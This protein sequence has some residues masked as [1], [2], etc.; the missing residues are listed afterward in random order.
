MLKV[1]K[2]RLLEFEDQL[3][4][5]DPESGRIPV[6]ILGYGEV[7]ATFQIGD[8][9][10]IAFKRMPPFPNERASV[11]YCNAVDECSQILAY[12][13][14]KVVDYDFTRI[15]N[16]A[17]EHMVYIIQPRFDAE[18][19][20]HKRLRNCTRAE[21]EIML[22][23]I[24]ENMAKLWR[25]NQK[26]GPGE[27]LGLDSQISN[28]VFSEDALKGDQQPAYFDLSTPL[29]RRNGK[30]MLDVEVF[31]KSIPSFLVWVVRRYVIQGVLDRYYDMRA[32]AIDL[33][34]NLYKEGH[35]QRIPVAIE[36]ANRFFKQDAPDLEIAPLT[37]KEIDNY[38]QGDKFIWAFLLACRRLDRFIKTR[39]LKKKY[40]FILPGPV[41][42]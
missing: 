10:D 15:T 39:L 5:A 4:P 41:K 36:T 29:Y 40:N 30:E 42:R 16:S 21:F 32:V 27:M 9:S 38:Y 34:A 26:D 31:L 6:K 14:I 11:E 24:L 28:W 25:K 8:I 22:V 37:Q 23:K 12:T 19:I 2:K 17:G 20:G 35:P 33:I 7:T 3:N 18:T 13:G 1:D